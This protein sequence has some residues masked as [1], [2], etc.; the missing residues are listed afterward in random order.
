M[1]L[2]N[3][4]VEMVALFENLLAT[5]VDESIKF[6]GKPSHAIAKIIETEIDV[7]E[8]VCQGGGLGRQ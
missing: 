2:S 8:G 3:I 4:H 7:W 6:L 5:F 1:K